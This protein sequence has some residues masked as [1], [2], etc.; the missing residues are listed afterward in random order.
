MKKRLIFGLFSGVLLLTGCGGNDDKNLPPAARDANFSMTVDTTLSEQLGS[1]DGNGDSLSYTLV[2]APEFGDL[3]VN[4]DG[5]FT[6][7]PPLEFTGSVVFSYAVS[8]GEL[9][10]EASVM[11]DVEAEQV[12]TSSYVRAAFGQDSRAQPLSVNGRVFTDNAQTTSEFDDLISG[13]K[14]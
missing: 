12:T 6:Y 5:S 1:Y 8:D 9:T 14:Q 7:T 13:G 11:I 3:T 4:N 2:A 10:D